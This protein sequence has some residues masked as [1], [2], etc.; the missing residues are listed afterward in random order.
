MGNVIIGTEKLF[1]FLKV[2]YIAYL[3][4]QNN[5]NQSVQLLH[6]LITHTQNPLDY[7]TKHMV[8]QSETFVENPKQNILLLNKD[9]KH[10]EKS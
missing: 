2:I 10:K 3:V 6:M 9:H 1:F 7:V 8:L 4:L 5:I